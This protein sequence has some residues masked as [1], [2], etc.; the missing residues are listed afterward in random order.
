MPGDTLYSLAVKNNTT[1]NEIK[2]ANNLITNDLII[3]QQIII[4]KDDRYGKSK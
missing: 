2:K 4:P 3:G 1:V